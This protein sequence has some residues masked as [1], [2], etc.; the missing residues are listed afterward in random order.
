MQNHNHDDT[1]AAIATAVGQAG[2]GIVRIS[3][4]EALSIADRVFVSKDGLRPSNFKTYT[5]H[6]GWVTENLK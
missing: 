5:T 4:C 3:G 2:I 6:Y 1:I